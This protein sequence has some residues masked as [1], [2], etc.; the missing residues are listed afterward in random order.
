MNIN[1]HLG[2]TI[3]IPIIYINLD[4]DIQRRTSIEN[5]CKYLDINCTRFSA[6]T[7]NNINNYKNYVAN[8]TKMNNNEIACSISHLSILSEYQTQKYII[9]FEDD[10]QTYASDQTFKNHVQRAISLVPNFDIVYFG[11]AGVT[12]KD[13]EL[14]EN[15][16]YRYRGNS[17]CAHAYMISNKGIKKILQESPI[18]KPIDLVYRDVLNKKGE[19]YVTLPSMITQ[20]ILNSTSNS[21]KNIDYPTMSDCIDTREESKSIRIILIISILVIILI[22]FINFIYYRLQIKYS[23]I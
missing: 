17:F 1:L 14:I 19:A 9:V 21:R 4:K 11:Q 16:L 8:K 10:I 15:P 13:T 7:S 6:I 2:N 23:S 12:C 20:N 18:N 22:L 3:H 5:V